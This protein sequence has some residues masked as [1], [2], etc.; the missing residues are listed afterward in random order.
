MM[1]MMDRN[2]RRGF[3]LVELLTV[4]GIIAVLAAILYPVISRAGRTAKKTQCESNIIQ[5]IMAIEL[6]KQDNGK[7]PPALMPYDPAADPQNNSVSRGLADAQGPLLGRYITDYTTFHCPMAIDTADYTAG[8]LGDGYDT[9][10]QARLV[11]GQPVV[12]YKYSTYDGNFRAMRDDGVEERTLYQIAYDPYRPWQGQP[13]HPNAK[14]YVGRKMWDETT[15]V[16][17]CPYHR[18]YKA[19]GTPTELV[20]SGG[21]M[22]LVG[23]LNKTVQ[24]VPTSE[25]LPPGHPEL[26]GFV[27]P[28]RN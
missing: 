1:R 14:R 15:V 11:G 13:D 10:T 9:I 20:P 8:R 2:R 3:T 28:K 18:D 24:S 26:W 5:I 27:E 25:N 22:D 21:S 12:V 4:I 23:F 19:G 6:Y 7:A 17:W 16:T